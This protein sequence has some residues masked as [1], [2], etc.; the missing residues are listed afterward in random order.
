LVAGEVL[1]GAIYILFAFPTW[2]SL[3]YD[4]DHHPY[5]LLFML[6]STLAFTLGAYIFCRLADSFLHILC[7][8]TGTLAALGFARACDATWDFRAYYSLPLIQEPR[9]TTLLRWSAALVFIA[10]FLF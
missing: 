2:I 7:L 3:L 6:G 4:E 1:V 5:L 9:Y 10:L 8:A